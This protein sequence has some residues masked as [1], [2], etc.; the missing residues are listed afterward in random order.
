MVIISPVISLGGRIIHTIPKFLPKIYQKYSA[1]RGYS[2]TGNRLRVGVDF[3]RKFDQKENRKTKHIGY[4]CI[5]FLVLEI[6]V[7]KEY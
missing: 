4:H 5:M 2:Q 7:Y 3:E 6:L 1:W